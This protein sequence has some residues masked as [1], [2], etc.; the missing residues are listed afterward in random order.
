MDAEQMISAFANRTSPAVFSTIDRHKLAEGL[1]IRVRNPVAINQGAASL[2]GPA[3]LV[4]SMALRD[5]AAYAKFVIDLYEQGEA[6]IGKF[7]IRPS[8]KLRKYDPPDKSIHDADWVP[9][10]S[11]RNSKGSIVF[12][13]QYDHI[14]D[15]APGI[16]VP[17]DLR[18]WLEEVGYQK[19]MDYTSAIGGMSF[20]NG[21]SN[22]EEA[23]LK[24]TMG[25]QVFL[26]IMAELLYE[27]GAGALHSKKASIKKRS[28][29][30]PNHWVV[31]HSGVIVGQSVRLAVYTWGGL[32]T[33]PPAGTSR[34]LDDVLG[35]Y[36]GF[37]AAM[38]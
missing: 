25:Y 2:C 14:E 18:K 5:R 19:V 22:L 11:I 17:A 4:Y 37:V 13:N 8:E 28:F 20:K 35:G 38:Y 31:L 34:T 29:G 15:E 1:K 12:F 10:A 6:K 27:E 33:I 36:Y 26:L 3:S 24:A 9:M 23:I 32:S 30:V 21:K 16:T 7:I